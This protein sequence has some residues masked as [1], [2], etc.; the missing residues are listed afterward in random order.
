MQ[1][2]RPIKAGKI[3]S[4]KEKTSQGKEE[5]NLFYFF[6]FTNLFFV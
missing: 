6:Y 3:K 1:L 5:V 4:S 2:L